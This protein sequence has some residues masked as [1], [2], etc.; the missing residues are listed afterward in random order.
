M[1]GPR[2]QVRP[3]VVQQERAGT[4]SEMPDRVGEK[5]AEAVTALTLLPELCCQRPLPSILLSP[6]YCMLMSSP[7]EYLYRLP[8]PAERLATGAFT[9]AET[10][11]F[12]RRLAEFQARG[13]PL[14][15]WVS[16]LLFGGWTIQKGSKED[17][18]GFFLQACSLHRCRLDKEPQHPSAAGPVQP[19]AAP[20]SGLPVLPTLC[21]ALWRR[22]WQT[23]Q[24][25][26]GSS[27]GMPARASNR[28]GRCIC[29]AGGK[30]PG[31][32]CG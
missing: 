3:A 5:T 24:A 31:R 16:R 32:S 21:K 29:G 2:N 25:I 30:A 22:R 28:R 13:W 1:E 26:S 12:D 18:A 15:C 27:G 8:V 17:R 20:P 11:A 19:G 14:S 7:N 10:A 23:S 6:P 9:D 4:G